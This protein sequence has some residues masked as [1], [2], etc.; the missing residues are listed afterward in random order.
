MPSKLDRFLET[1]DPSRNIEQLWSRADNALN[2]FS[3]NQAVVTDYWEFQRFLAEFFC[4][5]ENTLIRLNPPRKIEYDFDGGRCLHLLQQ[6]LGSKADKVAFDRARTGIDGG[7]YVRIPTQPGH[8]FRLKAATQSGAIRPVIPEHSGHLF[9]SN[10][11][12]LF[13]L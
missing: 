5:L 10:P 12:T 1:I 7:L 8:R 3:L 2:S 11:A 4:H 13:Y 9:R 6:E